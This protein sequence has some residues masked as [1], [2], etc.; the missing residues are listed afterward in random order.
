MP[1]INAP[2]ADHPFYDAR[3]GRQMAYKRQRGD[4]WEYTVK[5]AG[6]LERPLTLTFASEADGDAYCARLETLLDRGILPEEYRPETRVLTIGDLVRR[7]E[8]EVV[9]PAK[10]SEVLRTVVKAVGDL[11]TSVLTAN[12][13]DDWIASMKR[14]D[15]LA[16]ATI[17]AKVGALARACDWGMRK[18][19]VTLP[20]H[21]LR[22]L[23]D[24]YAQYTAADAAYVTP[25]EDIERER[26]LEPGEHERI[27][28][29]L[30]SGQ[31]A[32]KPVPHADELL[33]LYQLLPE[34]AMRL[35]ELYTVTPDQVDLAARA[36]FLSKTKNGDSRSVPL[37]SV[38]VQLFAGFAGFPWLAMHRGNLKLTSNYLSKLLI[39]AFEQAGCDD[40]RV[41]DLRHEATSRLF[42]RTTLSAEQVMKITGHKSHRMMMRYL[43]L[44]P[45]EL[46]ARLW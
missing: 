19:L 37:S 9:L 8:R 22:T 33:R 11:P 17:R 39:T 38:A 28:A 3:Q 10:D 2:F 12:W 1:T 41:H 44:R 5:R 42:E 16:P 43:K 32:G 30:A 40:L 20:D 13:V 26:R 4:S 35:R 23:R 36:V 29:V 14:H 24:G 6:V 31:I 21:P 27:V 46:A 7:Y 18:K 45:S 34:T 15:H 25:R